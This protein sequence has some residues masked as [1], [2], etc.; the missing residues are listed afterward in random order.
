MRHWLLA[1][2]LASQAT[3]SPLPTRAQPAAGG[4]AEPHSLS[5][6]A[7]QQAARRALAKRLVGELNLP[8]LQTEPAHLAQRP[9]WALGVASEGPLHWRADVY[10]SDANAGTHLA[11]GLHWPMQPGLNLSLVQVLPLDG[12]GERQLQLGA[13]IGF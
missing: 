13:R 4:A 3:L 10:R 7:Q 2:A 6:P 1:A 5:A 12:S 9:R 11:A 8:W